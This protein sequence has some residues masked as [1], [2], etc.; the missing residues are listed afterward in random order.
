MLYDSYSLS[1]NKYYGFF[2]YN[3]LKYKKILVFFNIY[4]NL[5]VFIQHYYYKIIIVNN[6]TF[7]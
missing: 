1:Y 6:S 4:Y 3:K 2:K 7:I 5:F